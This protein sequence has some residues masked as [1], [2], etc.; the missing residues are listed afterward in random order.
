MIR[1]I[2]SDYPWYYPVLCFAGALA[3]TAVS[4]YRNRKLAEF[5]SYKIYILAALRFCALFIISLLLLNIFVKT[6][7]N[8]TEKPILA[9]AVDNSE[10]VLMRG[11]ES[12]DSMKTFVS[13]LLESSQRLKEK[14]N[15]KFYKFGEKLAPAANDF[16]FSDKY[17][18]FSEMFESMK[19]VLYN[20]NAGAMVVCSDGIFNKGQNPVYA[21]TS[22]GQ[23]VYTVTL[24]DTTSYK[25]LSIIK[26][27]YNETSFLGNEFPL[28]ITINAKMLKGKNTICQVLHNGK[29]EFQKPLSIN[30]DDFS[31]EITTTL[32]AETKGLQKYTIVLKSVEGEITTIN[33]QR[34]IVIDVVDDKYKILIL[35]AMPHP[36]VAALR[37][38][39]SLNRG[40]E[41]EVA[42]IDD[43]QKN[44]SSYNLVVLVQLPS[45]KNKAEK[46]LAE[47]K[48]KNIPSLF[49]LGS[50]TDYAVFNANNI[51]IN[52]SKKGNNYDD[53]GIS[54]NPQFS[55]FSF[56]NG[57][58]EFLDK[59]PP[60]Y[61]A[62]GDYKVMS[63]T[64]VFGTQKIKGIATQ[65][66]LIAVAEPSKS[67]SAVIAGEGIWRWR[68][69]CYKR[70]LNHE[71]FDLMFSRLVQFLLT[72]N[73]RERFSITS[74]RIFSENEPVYFNA[75]VFDEMLEPVSDAEVK[76]EISGEDDFKV[77]EKFENTGSGYY[78]RIDNLKP[79]NYVYKA[80]AASNGKVLIK[81]GLFS[82]VEIKTEAENLTANHN[83]M[84]KIAVATSAESFS[85]ENYDKLVDELMNNDKIKP[86]IYAD[87]ELVALMSKKILFYIIILLLAAE[88]FLRKYWGTL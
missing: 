43:F 59:V 39:L 12:K 37:S 79:G 36:D 2:V 75:K 56:E 83:I 86:M 9:I 50:E 31:Q 73:D 76:M 53:A 65:K 72:R 74:K 88:W 8:R 77:N 41:L 81:N 4:Y 7:T 69:D 1:T 19:S 6:Q 11:N 71:K 30:S 51:C 67:K 23:K 64:Q 47:I 21:A 57:I 16:T 80:T 3:L 17:T 26:T 10:S 40:Y 44:V 60:L 48:N 45:V 87:T 14:Y 63:A 18:N 20:T 52:V 35:S 85:S 61:C 58:D 38:A 49:I 15:V 29:T 46:I 62:F 33:N 5:Q 84:R 55:L 28:E 82:V 42:T 78:L 34:E 25:D 66:P 70:Y 27:V 68:I 54:M 32:K 13:K 22:L 24:G